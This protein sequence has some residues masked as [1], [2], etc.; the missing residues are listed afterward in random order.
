MHQ[1]AAYWVIGTNS[2]DRSGVFTLTNQG[3]VS[4]EHEDL[5]FPDLGRPEASWTAETAEPSWTS[6]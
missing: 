5:E 6:P 4:A 3:Y 2:F 1:G